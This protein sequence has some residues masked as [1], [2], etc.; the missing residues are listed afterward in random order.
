[1]RPLLTLLAALAVLAAAGGLYHLK[2]TVESRREAVR[3]LE[4]QILEDTEAIRVLKAEWAYL[5][6]PDELQ[7]RARKHL[8]LRPAQP[9]Q[10]AVSP[11]VLP[12][13]G[14]GNGEG[15][16]GPLAEGDGAANRPRVKPRAPEAP[17]AQAAGESPALRADGARASRQGKPE[18]KADF[19]ERMQAVVNR[20][21]GER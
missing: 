16:L 3:A 4:A 9:E 14:G 15:D 17:P 12:F 5:T 18:T 11:A 7:K 6:S 1:M 21:G 10:I 13:R 19:T 2:Y 8:K 20:L